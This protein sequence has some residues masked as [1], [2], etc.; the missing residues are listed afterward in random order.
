MGV[1][2]FPRTV[3]TKGR[4]DSGPASADSTPQPRQLRPGPEDKR[5]GPVRLRARRAVH[6]PSAKHGLKYGF[7]VRGHTAPTRPISAD[8]ASGTASW[9]SSQP[10]G[11]LASPRAPGTAQG[12]PDASPSLPASAVALSRQSR[13]VPDTPRHKGPPW[14]PSPEPFVS[15]T[16]R[17]RTGPAPG[18]PEQGFLRSA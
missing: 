2:G 1:G 17:W 4:T 18:S 9:A 3:R 12:E 11:G 6:T 8:P 16:R 13:G 10:R 15:C 5:Q 7:G 14:G